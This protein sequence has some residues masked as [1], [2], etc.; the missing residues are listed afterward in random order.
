MLV[1]TYVAHENDSIYGDLSPSSGCSVNYLFTLL[2]HATTGM[3]SS[4]FSIL[5]KINYI[6]A[7]FDTAKPLSYVYAHLHDVTP[8]N[9]V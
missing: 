8:R 4:H 5:N 7:L 2:V 9:S 6:T 3:S 1:E